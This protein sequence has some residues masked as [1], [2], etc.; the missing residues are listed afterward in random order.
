MATPRQNARREINLIINEMI[1]EL[2][3]TKRFTLH[4]DEIAIKVVRE[5]MG[6]HFN[7]LIAIYHTL[8]NVIPPPD[9]SIITPGEKELF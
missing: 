8:D 1:A 3:N 7:Q 6:H 5:S 2:H 9:Q 4:L